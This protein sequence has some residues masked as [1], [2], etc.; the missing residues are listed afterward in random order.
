MIDVEQLRATLRE[1]LALEADYT[2]IAQGWMRLQLRGA[3]RKAWLKKARKR[4][5]ELR[6]ELQLFAN[7]DD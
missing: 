7:A 3:A 5:N 4:L 1:Y 6:A 2:P